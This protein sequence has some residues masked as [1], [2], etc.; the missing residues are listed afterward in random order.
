MD[1]VLRLLAWTAPSSAP[2]LFDN[3][4][5]DDA[6]AGSDAGSDADE[7]PVLEG[8]AS[9]PF[10][11]EQRESTS[12]AADIERP[13]D[14]YVCPITTM[15]LVDPVVLSSGISFEKENIVQWLARDGGC[16][17]TRA[18]ASV[19]AHN[20]TLRTAIAEWA[21]GVLARDAQKHAEKESKKR[22]M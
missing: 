22:K 16:P 6:D 3:L 19:V 8:E 17:M 20:V 2:W 7:E 15:V 5:A 14:A 10:L 11:R 13:P 21:T 18:P 9:G 1:R 4:E 12:K